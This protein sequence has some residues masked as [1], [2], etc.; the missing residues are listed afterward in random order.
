MRIDLSS[1]SYLL[2][3]NKNW[4]FL[5]DQKKINFSNYGEIFSF[6]KKSKIENN[7]DIK[8]IFLADILDFHSTENIKKNYKKLI[9]IINTIKKNLLFSKNPIIVGV[10]NYQYFNII[11]NTKNKNS[12]KILKEF[13]FEELYKIV[14][15]FNNLYIIDIDEVYSEHGLK[16]CFDN[17]N[18]YLSR[19]RLSYFGIEILA[20]NLKKI[21]NRIKNP[22]KKVL[23]LDCDN[24]L[25]GG[26]VAEDGIDKIKIQNEGEGFAFYDFQ[27]T[28][29]KI[30]N[31]GILLVL[32][33]KNNHE[34]VIN[35]FKKRK[36]MI[37]ELKDIAFFK[38]N[39]KEKTNNI[40]EL[41][42]DLDLGLES[43][44]FWDDNPIERE[45]VRIN[46]KTVEVIEP[47][48]DISNW[49]K[50]LLEYQGFSKF[51]LTA[52][53]KRKTKYYHQRAKFIV[54]KNK[55]KDEKDYLRSIKPKATIKKLNQTNL[56]RA[57]QM[58]QKTN[59]FNLSTKR[60][61]HSDILKLKKNYEFYL[62]NL[63]DNYGDHGIIGMVCL[64]IFKNKIIL[65]DTFLMSCRVL[66]RYLENWILDQVKKIAKKN[67]IKYIAAEYVASER[68]KIVN[69][70]LKKNNFKKKK[71]GQI[72]QRFKLDPSFFDNKNTDY[73]I[74]QTKKKVTDL[75]IYE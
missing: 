31:L 61:N 1:T 59:Q 22:N 33:S 10:S 63:K 54:N 2:E 36:S 14:K 74:T 42:K 49:S 41:A 7:Y 58:T 68:N 48:L 5:E 47:D 51:N 53:D 9:N 13:F 18:Y 75:D 66:G 12:Q 44:A 52:S 69:D 23:L 29:K 73:F 62:I 20:K 3:N 46:L 55:F 17:R 37:L 21:L 6:R 60:Y 50:Q 67:S 34:D 11:E 64:K 72:A 26:V 16:N 70:F 40:I 32:V 56:D 45:K 71:L 43:F 38:I 19:C 15:K 35:V 30:K 8:I 27:K 39:W 57:V 65:I 4:N 28:I 24:T 25:W